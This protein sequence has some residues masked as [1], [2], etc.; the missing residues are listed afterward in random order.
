MNYL[1]TNRERF[2]DKG[3]DVVGKHETTLPG[4]SA[5]QFIPEQRVNRSRVGFS[6]GF[7]HHLT[8]EKAQ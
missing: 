4:A 5:R 1:A 2:E 7:L 8:N 6:L 3:N